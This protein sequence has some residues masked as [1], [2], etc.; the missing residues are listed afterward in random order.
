MKPIRWVQ[1][2]AVLLGAGA[3]AS[4]LVVT[5]RHV[6]DTPQPLESGLPGEA[7]IDRD[8][9]GQLYYTVAG[10]DEAHP[11]VLLHDFY[12]GA[13]SYEYSAVF[14]RLAGTHRVY[15][16]DWLGFGMSEHPALAYTGEFY[17]DMLA[18]YLRDVIARPATVVAIGRAVN[19][20]VRAASDDPAL[21]ERLVLIS[22]DI[23]AGIHLNPTL[24]QAL[25]RLA[26]RSSLGL[27]PHAIVSSR[28]V[29][30]L[31][32]MR[33][34]LGVATEDALDHEW[35]AAHQFG[36]QYAVL[37]TLTGELDLPIQHVLALLEPPVLLVAGEDDRQRTRE[38]MEELAVLNPHADLD[39][40]PGAGAAVCQD[41][42]ARFV[43]ALTHW[44]QREAPRHISSD[45]LRIGSPATLTQAPRSPTS[46]RPASNGTSTL[47]VA[48]A[49]QDAGDLRTTTA[50]KHASA[51]PAE[52]QQAPIP[53]SR[54]HQDALA[55]GV[56]ETRTTKQADSKNASAHQQPPGEP[57]IAPPSAQSPKGVTSPEPPARTRGRSQPKRPDVSRAERSTASGPRADA[58]D[59][60]E[61]T[62]REPRMSRRAPSPTPPRSAGRT[63]KPMAETSNGTQRGMRGSSQ[64]SQEK[65]TSTGRDRARNGTQPHRAGGPR[66]TPEPE[67]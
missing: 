2:G 31:R 43:A 56:K 37:A 41:Q 7:R 47:R 52:P 46:T 15:A 19:V 55:D 18:G 53:A 9:G 39:V 26:Q 50:V 11:I 59:T 38:D 23:A 21:F 5:T 30:R 60:P 13:S 49:P 65:R 36:A 8:H 62:G 34:G 4:A 32:A 51:V 20:A 28:P 33:R 29:L 64:D 16:P 67:A 3:A 48:P 66:N 40:I 61:E 6:L 22:P 1:G 10:P 14:A 54:A 12:P 58:K 35:A 63:T 17:A 42:P 44:M 25:V 57:D 24:T 27:L 45:T